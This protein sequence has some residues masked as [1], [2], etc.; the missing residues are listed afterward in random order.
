MANH[1]NKHIREA[2]KYAEQNGW[3]VVKASGKAHIWGTLL[4]PLQ[5]R[6]GCYFHVHSTPRNPESH[7]KR[8]RK[9]VD[10][11]QHY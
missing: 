8:I 7:T 3:R 5:E 11:C 6:E 9:A 2:I 1:P 4:C 10:S